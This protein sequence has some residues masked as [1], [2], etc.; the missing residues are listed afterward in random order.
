ML[1]FLSR[2]KLFAGL[3][4]SSIIAGPLQA[5]PGHEPEFG[6]HVGAGCQARADLPKF[7]RFANR[8]VVRVVDAFNQTSW[9]EFQS[10]IPW[11]S[12]CWAGAPVKLT[13]SVPMLVYSGGGT[14]AEGAAGKYDDIFTHIAQTLVADGHNDI[15]IRLGWE[16]NG[17]WM[18]WAASKDPANFIAYYR[19]IVGL[20]RK[21]PGQK[22][23]FEWTPNVGRQ[24]FAPDKGYPGDDVVDI[25]GMDIYNEYWTV[26]LANSK[27]RFAWFLNQPY[28]LKWHRD[29]AAQHRKPMA[30]SEW[31]S[32]TRKDGNAPGDDPYFITQ[33][34]NWMR[35]TNT[36][37]HSYW[38]VKNQIYDDTVSQGRHP[39]AAAAFK[40]AFGG[41]RP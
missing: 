22:F 41:R 15:V 23:R 13:L 14:L 33:M 9:Q 36:L 11:I 24:N 21:V 4:L 28:G 35:Q 1:S 25:I 6:V 30:Y 18:P 26:A 38:E 39:K 19:R 16:F 20:M 3:I 27:V 32:G 29:F 37:Y 2:R 10:S 12:R 5:A 7:E 40:S 31:G 34:A 17:N 8:K